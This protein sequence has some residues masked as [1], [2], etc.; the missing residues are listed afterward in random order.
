MAPTKAGSGAV[1]ELNLAPIRA[2][3]RGE[4][5]GKSVS[6]GGAHSEAVGLHGSRASIG[7]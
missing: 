7:Q 5:S 2:N 4:R 3:G 1:G 6:L